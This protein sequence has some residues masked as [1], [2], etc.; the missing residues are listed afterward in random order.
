M[1]KDVLRMAVTLSL[2][3]SLEW[4]FKTIKINLTNNTQLFQ[5]IGQNMRLN[6]QFSPAGIAINACLH[7]LMLFKFE[8]V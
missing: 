4:L 2:S 8:L 3:V 1:N 5:K 6:E 7:G